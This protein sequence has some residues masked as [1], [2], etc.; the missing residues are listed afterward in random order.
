MNAGRDF[1]H[2]L[3]IYGNYL[4]SAQMRWC[5]RMLKLRPFEQ[6]IGGDRAVSYVGI[7]A[8][9]HRSGYISHKSNITTVFPFKEDGITKADVIRI[10]E[11]S[12]IGL[13][14]YYAWRTRSGCYFCFFQRKMEW[15]GLRQ[16]HP[17]LYEAAKAYEKMVPEEEQGLFTWSDGESLEDLEQPERVA[18]IRARHEA[19]MRRERSR[20][21]NRSLLEVLEDVLDDEDDEKPCLICQL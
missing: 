6:F 5:T 17:E 11:Q 19:E 18:E 3:K 15:V 10:L 7:R 2:W 8:D 12:G 13:P 16:H 1:D 14:A 21:P 4:P 9:E 20:Q